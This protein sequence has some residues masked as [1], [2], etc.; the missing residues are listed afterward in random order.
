MTF[1]IFKN[2][3]LLFVLVMISCGSQTK[4]R[5]TSQDEILKQVQED[6]SI[7]VGANQIEKYLPLLKGK[8][9]GIVANQTSVIFKGESYR[10]VVDSLVS[11]KVNITNVFSP[12]HGFRGTADAGEKVTDGVDQKTGI[13]IISLYSANRKPKLEQLK[14]TKK[15]EEDIESGVS[16]IDIMVFDLQDVGVRFYTYISTLHYIM[17]ACAESNIPLIILDRPNP[18]GHYI[19]GP[20]LEIEHNS[21]VGMHPIPVTHGMTIGEYAQMINGEKWLANGVQ[22]EFTVV[23]VKNYTHNTAYDLPIKPSPNLPNDK[24]ISLYPSLCFF[25][26]T[27]VSVGRGTDKQFQV[28][29]SPYFFLKRY[30]YEFTPQP[31]EGA[32]YPKHQ[33]EICNGYDLSNHERLNSINLKWL[34]EFYQENKKNSPDQEFFNKFFVKLAGTTKLQ[35]QIKAGFTEE[36]ITETWQIGIQSFKKIRAKYLIYN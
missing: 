2:T 26:G 7:I 36:E 34:I 5:A 23:P 10:H 18:N 32:K 25:E 15:Y 13:P 35:K 28:V 1:N 16:A 22:C 11:L 8:R 33:G 14:E 24:A 27:N 4:A 21:F 3:V 17:E 20:T 29:G 9:V 12:E 6:T 19:D 31:N 30:L